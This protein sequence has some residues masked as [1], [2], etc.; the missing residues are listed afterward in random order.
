MQ[1]EQLPSDISHPV[2][3]GYLQH[4]Q[5]EP[6]LHD[7]QGEILM[8]IEPDG[9]SDVFCRNEYSGPAMLR[10]AD[11][12]CVNV[13]KLKDVRFYVGVMTPKG[14]RFHSISREKAIEHVGQWIFGNI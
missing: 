4:T 3:A 10:H 11:M 8:V 13:R 1:V 5:N 7:F 9:I 2:T 12:W 14:G 6:L